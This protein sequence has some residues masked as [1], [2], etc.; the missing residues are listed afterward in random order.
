MR[1]IVHIQLFSSSCKKIKALTQIPWLIKTCGLHSF[2][3]TFYLFFLLILASTSS[4]LAKNLIF[5]NP[6]TS[7]FVLQPSAQLTMNTPSSQ[8]SSW[9]I[10]D[11]NGNMMIPTNTVY[12]I[13]TDSVLDGQG[14][15]ITIGDYAQLFVDTDITLT[16]RNATIQYAK[17]SVGLPPIRLAASGSKL[18]LDNVKV[19]LDGDFNFKQG[20][21]FVHNDVTMSGSSAFIYTSPVPSWITS[22]SRLFFDLNTTFSITPATFTDAP[23]TLKNTYTDCNFIKMADK[24]SQL[25]L[26]GCSLMTTYTGCRVTKGT[27]AFDR[28]VNAATAA[29]TTI[30]S[31]STQV[32]SAVSS[33]PSPEAIKW[34]T[35]NRFIAIGDSFGYFRIYRFDGSSTPI[36]IGTYVDVAANI[37]S[38][39]WSLDGKFIA[40]GTQAGIVGIYRFD[41]TTTPVLIGSKITA[42]ANIKTV[43]WS[44]NNR[45]IAIGNYDTTNTLKI[46]QFDG[47]STPIIIGSP[48]EVGNYVTCLSW[49]P[50][51]KYIAAGYGSTP[52][53]Y[54][55]IY[56]FNGST[57]ES[58]DNPIQAV[59]YIKSIEWSPDSRFLAATGY[60]TSNNLGIYRFNG[61]SKPVLIGSIIT[62]DNSGSYSGRWS[63]C[64]RFIVIGGGSGQVKIYQFN[65]SSS[66]TL[67]GTGVTV[68]SNALYSVDWSPDATFIATAERTNTNNFRIY[69][70]TYTKES[71]PQAFSKSIVFGDSAKGAD[72]DAD[73]TFLGKAQVKLNGQMNYDCVS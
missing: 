62:A 1:K 43:K 4:T 21:L 28:T 30:S 68:G 44:P 16:I 37:Q 25:Y 9:G 15:T 63:S 58:I 54:L 50:D 35:D 7:K 66:P 42:G 49:S 34:S 3:N 20:Q 14:N 13:T 57:V 8:I 5:S 56:S 47:I 46:Y 40:V 19:V 67:V 64:G 6:I 69:R 41:G 23:Y 59:N 52:P 65:G 39:E 48:I 71:T 33:G 60:A 10:T 45:F 55:R 26:N 17:T 18:A 11:N 31:Y 70:V 53:N 32:G 12:H 61:S 73:V 22:N 2:F 29:N 27:V 24:T 36:L 72:Y 51:G 38:I